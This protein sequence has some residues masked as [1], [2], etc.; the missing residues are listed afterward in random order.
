VVDRRSVTSRAFAADPRSLD[1]RRDGSRGRRLVAN[2]LGS[3]VG[4][5]AVR[6][7]GGSQEVDA[8][9]SHPGN[10]SPVLRRI[11]VAL[12]SSSVV[13]SDPE[14][15]DGTPVFVGTRVPVKNLF[16]YLEGGDRLEDFLEQFP[17]VSHDQAVAALDLAEK[18]LTSGANPSR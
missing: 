18:A 14:I 8:V 12:K 4:I 11:D 13:H 2:G 5:H 16:D 15:L 3:E 10:L 9:V 6:P 1:T 7:P 17:S